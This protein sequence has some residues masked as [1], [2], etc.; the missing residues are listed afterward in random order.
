MKWGVDNALESWKLRKKQKQT[1][2]QNI[3]LWD[4]LADV[5]VE[6]STRPGR[7]VILAITDGHDRGSKWD[8]KVVTNFAQSTGTAVFGLNY[9]EGRPAVAPMMVRGEQE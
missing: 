6:T 2:D 4:G 3:H 5:V 1:C 9:L 7:R 8:W